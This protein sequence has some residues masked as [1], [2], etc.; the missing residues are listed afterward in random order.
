IYFKTKN[1]NSK[2]LMIVR[3][4]GMHIWL[5]IKRA[6]WHLVIRIDW[7]LLHLKIGIARSLWHLWVVIARPLWAG[8]RHMYLLR[9]WLR[10][11]DHSGLCCLSS[12]TE[13]YYAHDYDED[14]KGDHAHGN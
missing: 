5:W 8:I 1:S 2:S 12:T 3:L 7:T 14:D 10:N 4:S 11:P 9:L 13:N 6:L